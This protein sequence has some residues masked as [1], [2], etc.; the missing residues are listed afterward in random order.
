[1]RERA[2]KYP[3]MLGVFMLALC[4]LSAKLGFFWDNVLLSSK[5]AHFFYEQP[6]NVFVPVDAV[7]CGH[8]PF[9]GI[10]LANVWKLF[11]KSLFVSHFAM[12]PIL[13]ILAW[14]YWKLLEYFLPSRLYWLGVLVFIL[15][16][17]LI[18]QCTM[19]SNEVVQFTGFIWALSLIV[20]RKQNWLFLPTVMMTA[21]SMRSVF[22]VVGLFTADI[23]WQRFKAKKWNFKA[24]L[25]YLPSALFFVLWNYYHYQEVGW[26]FLNIGS[27]WATEYGSS[28]PKEFV[29][30]LIV[31]LWHFVDFGR[32]ILYLLVLIPLWNIW[33]NKS[34]KSIYTEYV[35]LFIASL[36]PLF[37]F[38]LS[39][40]IP[41]GHRYLTGWYLLFAL[42]LVLLSEQIKWKNIKS[43]LVIFICSL[44]LLT[45][46][47]WTYP[48]KIAQ[49]WDSTLGHIPYFLTRAE[50]LNFI[51]AK[52]IPT[53]AVAA[54]YTMHTPSKFIVLN[55]QEED[56]LNKNKSWERADYVWYSNIVNGFTDAEIDELRSDWILLKSIESF[57]IKQ[58]L[59]KRNK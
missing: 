28:G 56:F 25:P 18:A 50:M 53:N 39:R 36:M 21:V 16:P 45:G 37:L 27:R 19:V 49:G 55:E 41:I 51:A 44:F 23:L 38:L 13:L 17:T 34:W 35:I 9:F 7:D 30:N 46:N 2:Y 32:I 29:R 52:D 26:A 8:P 3:A 57:G 6:W 22:V 15:E 48:D 31:M 47:L 20:Q 58:E 5:L 54:G 24:V 33:K 11:D 4:L 1:M 14:H 43:K 59:Y 12:L 42:G 10:Y 40:D